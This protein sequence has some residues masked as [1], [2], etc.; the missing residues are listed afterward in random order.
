MTTTTTTTVQQNFGAAA[1]D[2]VTSSYHA[3]GPDLAAL[4]AA[5]RLAGTERVLDCG[6]GAGHTALAMAAA[7]A[8]EVVGI[9]LTAEMVDAATALARTRGLANV[10]FE[11]ADAAALPFPDRSFDIVTNR[12]SC[13]HYA[14]L[15]AAVAETAR[16]LRPGGA[17]LLVDSMAP[18]DAAHDTFLNTV[19]LL[20][21][22]SHV[23]DRSI[24]EWLRLLRAAGLVPE[25]L[26][27]YPIPLDGADWVA[28]MRT[29]A[30]KVA[31]IRTLF[32]EAGAAERRTFE[33]RDEPWGFS[34]PG[35]LIRAVKA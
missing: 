8:A 20:R 18:E 6:T 2:Y 16:V 34:I 4:V 25:V 24:S 3:N 29:A 33:I 31:M 10:R 28:R 35:A 22:A 17:F 30:A 14:D 32:S 7:G 12:Q 11:R 21:D 26:D 5:A 27:R 15:A 9:D 1:S 23:R 13:H 19:E